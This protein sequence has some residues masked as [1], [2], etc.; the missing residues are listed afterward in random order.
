MEFVTR[1]LANKMAVSGD[2]KYF[3]IS[4]NYSGFRGIDLFRIVDRKYLTIPTSGILEGLSPTD[5]AFIPGSTLLAVGLS[6]SPWMVIVNIEGQSV[7]IL[8]TPTGT[9]A[10]IINSLAASPVGGYLAI[11]HDRTSSGAIGTVFKV[12]GQTLNKLREFTSSGEESLATVFSP[13]SSMLSFGV[14]MDYSESSLMTYRRSGDTFTALSSSGSAPNNVRALSF[15]FDNTLLAAG[16]DKSSAHDQSLVINRYDGN[17]YIKGTDAINPRALAPISHLSY[18]PKNPV[19]AV[20]YMPA[21]GYEQ[22]IFFEVLGGLHYYGGT[23]TGLNGF[24]YGLEFS[25]NNNMLAVLMRPVYSNYS[26]FTAW[27]GGR[28]SNQFPRSGFVPP[29]QPNT[30]S[31]SIAVDGPKLNRIELFSTLQDA[32]KLRWRP[33]GQSIYNEINISGAQT[34][35]SIPANTFN[36]D[37]IEW[38]VQLK[39][40]DGPWSEESEWFTL[41]T[42]D[43]ISNAFARAPRNTVIDGTQPNVFSWDHVIETGTSQTAAQL[44]YT[45]EETPG[46]WKQLSMFSGPQTSVIV[47]S[48]TLSGGRIL[49]RV[50]TGNYHS[51]LGN[52]SD[53]AAVVVRAAP[54]AP[55]ISSITNAARPV[56][57]WQAIGQISYE[58]VIRQGALIVYSTG[59]QPGASKVQAVTEFLDDGVYTVSVRVKNNYGLNSPWGDGAITISTEKPPE[60]VLIAVPLLNGVHLNIEWDD[61]AVFRYILRDGIPIAQISGSFYEDYSGI[62]VHRY[63]ARTVNAS[64]SFSDS[65]EVFAKTTITYTT[66]AHVNDLSDMLFLKWKP[67][68]AVGISGTAAPIASYHNFAGRKFPV[69]SS[70]RFRGDSYTIQTIFKDDESWDKLNEFFEV[71]NTMLYR[72]MRGHKFYFGFNQ[73]QM[74]HT[75]TLMQV[76]ISVS[77]VDHIERISYHPPEVVT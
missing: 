43:A 4:S 18:S 72:D 12:S 69:R 70:S 34:T 74:S 20:G 67:Q 46:E 31:W 68:G 75:R 53:P 36:T 33:Q 27:F 77:V 28:P 24:S 21:T 17:G 26:T 30:F 42:K 5:M 37:F 57:R 76:D 38:Q 60:A 6:V 62:G 63:V 45:P 16:G 54:P 56:I 66:M 73:T 64:D 13:D 71:D 32:A 14:E 58:L 22:I 41:T 59:E 2:G 7:S 47:P 65:L 1:P 10:V 3:A 50:R 19:L 35:Y 40:I 29:S 51:T 25:D 23:A 49:W 9:P 61:S 39:P 8:P 44:Q 55:S 48:N 11:A 52:W 15:S